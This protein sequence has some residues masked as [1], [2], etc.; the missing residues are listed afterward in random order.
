VSARFRD[1]ARHEALRYG[2]DPWVFVRELIQNARD[3]G[4]SE[5]AFRVAERDGLVRLACRDDG[6]GMDLA[7]ARRYLFALYASSKDGDSGA[8]G[9]FGV[10]FWSVLRFQPARILIRSWPRRGEGWEAEL[11]GTLDR[12]EVRPAPRRAGTGTEVMLERSAGGEDVEAMVVEAAGRAAR[13][14]GRRDTFG[15]A[16]PVRVNG[17]S[18]SAPFTLP[19]PSLGF[20]R[21]RLRGVVALREEPSFELLSRGL[22]VRSA[23]SLEELLSPG[24][25]IEPVRWSPGRIAPQALLDG[26]VEVLLARGDARPTRP[27]TRLVALARAE[28]GR[29]MERQLALVRPES[30]RRRAVAAGRR[31]GPVIALAALL[32]FASSLL[33]GVGPRGETAARPAATATPGPRM[34]AAEIHPPVADALLPYAD[35]GAFYHGPRSDGPAVN[36]SIGLRY[37]PEDRSWRF[38]ALRLDRPDE[39]SAAARA[40]GAYE[41]GACTTECLSVELLVEDGPGALRVPV[42]TG[43]RLD[44]RSLRLEGGAVS[45]LASETDEPI[46]ILSR[47]TLGILRYRTGPSHARITGATTPRRPVLPPSLADRA[48][49][50]RDRPVSDRVAALV[51]AVQRL[52][53][54][55]QASAVAEQDRAALARGA[56]FVER[57][58][59]VGAGDCDVQNGLLV[60][61]LHEADVHARLAVGYVGV[62]G[63][64]VPGLHAWAEYADDAGD[65]RAADASGEGRPPPLAPLPEVSVAGPV[66]IPRADAGQRTGA[67]RWLWIA[68]FVTLGVGGAGLLL[69]RTRRDVRLD[70]SA[71]VVG[72][73]RAA[74]EHPGSFA[75]APAVFTREVVPLLGGARIALAEAHRLSNS[76]RLFTSERG[77][78]LARHAAGAG[79]RV[80]D[81]RHA[82]AQV[83]SDGLGAIDLDAWD[84]ALARSRSHPLLDAAAAELRRFGEPWDVRL[85]D[86]D[87]GAGILD[88]P[89]RVIVISAHDP[90]WQGVAPRHET[91]P[92]EALFTVLE[93]LTERLAWAPRRR[94]RFLAGL[95]AR[96]VGEAAP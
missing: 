38:A 2:S 27:L 81:A 80:L 23:S 8:A 90:L 84:E 72:L 15:S 19:P 65:W 3:A 17:R 55:S 95:A 46:V 54:Y 60:L 51:S 89:Q 70:P 33:L 32:G 56:T 13:H 42:P 59:T 31:F 93:W 21:G 52:V 82:E 48:R 18:V 96:A 77:S 47:R 4:A 25:G 62:A 71:D 41:G 6:S 68:G 86:G 67:G 7:H 79:L 73:L 11:S 49:A 26:D 63:R 87:V 83:V 91:S 74:L 34:E 24:A 40:V 50:L 9:C 78:T 36:R 45:A 28:L 29:L 37:T 35:L 12:V 39:P 20:R 43:H 64:T 5:V 85:A 75:E 44:P 61:L 66:A 94:A 22:H 10:G 16:L 69:R 58:L 1:R 76:G 92:R 30:M 57:A 53:S 88:L 14:L